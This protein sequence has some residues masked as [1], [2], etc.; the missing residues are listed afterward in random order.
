MLPT[1]LCPFW[2][3]YPGPIFRHT[4]EAVSLERCRSCLKHGTWL[5]RGEFGPQKKGNTMEHTKKI[6]IWD[7]PPLKLMDFHSYRSLREQDS[8]IL[9][10]WRI[11]EHVLR[12]LCT[13]VNSIGCSSKNATFQKI[14]SKDGLHTNTYTQNHHLSCCINDNKTPL[15]EGSLTISG[16]VGH[17]NTTQS[18][19]IRFVATKKMLM[20]TARKHSHVGAKL[21]I[22]HSQWQ[23]D[24][25]WVDIKKNQASYCHSLLIDVLI[26]VAQHPMSHF[27]L[28]TLAIS[29]LSGHHKM[30]SPN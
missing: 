8:L 27:G 16:S 28:L 26:A 14:S 23:S 2:G 5:E 12:E 19:D 20:N 6:G 18:L 13:E 11:L 4:Q 30:F 17:I 10:S 25:M 7:N 24:I 9:K 29:P 1:L 21:Q 22:L 15:C 3:V